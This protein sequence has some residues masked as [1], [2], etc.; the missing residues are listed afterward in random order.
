MKLD[1]RQ[2]SY[3]LRE[4]GSQ[5]LV[6][7]RDI[8]EIERTAPLSQINSFA[9]HKGVL[10]V[11]DEI[12]ADE[13]VDIYSGINLL[14]FS[15]ADVKLT[16][17]RCPSLNLLTV[18][19]VS[20]RYEVVSLILSILGG[21]GEIFD[22]KNELLN[23]LI[24]NTFS[25]GT[26]INTLTKL[27]GNPFGVFDANFKTIVSSFKEDSLLPEYLSLNSSSIMSS[28]LKDSASVFTE[29]R[30]KRFVV[31]PAVFE[32]IS[33][34]YVV[35]VEINI[36][37]S[38]EDYALLLD[39]SKAVAIEMLKGKYSASSTAVSEEEFLLRLISGETVSAR[40]VEKQSL[41][42]GVSS[43]L[44]SECNYIGVLRMPHDLSEYNSLRM[45][46]L[47]RDVKSFF[48]LAVAAAKNDHLILLF[49]GSRERPL[50]EENEAAF[51]AFLKERRILAGFSASFTGFLDANIYY[52]Q[53]INA[54]LLFE[55][56]EVERSFIAIQDY[57]F[58]D[59]LM[60]ISGRKRLQNYISG[61]I[62]KLI[63]CD[64]N[65]GTDYVE[66]LRQLLENGCN[67]KKTAERM[68]V[69]RNTLLYRVK[70]IETVSGL[71]FDNDEDMFNAR[72]SIK[73]L[74]FM[75]HPVRKTDDFVLP[76]TAPD[77][78][79]KQ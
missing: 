71:S 48:G 67:V 57:L 10:F 61:K 38:A 29:P 63:I 32:G 15:D 16:R 33:L 66:T 72:M 59:L 12:T 35:M 75:S 69:H 56:I 58:F 68:F 46:F 18:S 76:H 79:K 60:A 73:I 21:D 51:D 64:R 9:E 7:R 36:V 27:V 78:R 43:L 3:I 65:E 6:S 13:A 62:M 30:G 25:E 17:S 37:W 50:S 20:A 39:I 19:D 2:L 47:M 44:A 4:Y 42:L 24:K 53:A 55:R 31:V 49:R 5:L 8:W 14:I 1:L 54:S 52:N 40:Y 74:E 23:A 45:R 26:L 34:G 70:K 41:I 28:L 77:S 11:A 22:H